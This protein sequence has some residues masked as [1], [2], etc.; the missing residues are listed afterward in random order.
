ME[1]PSSAKKPLRFQTH[2]ESPTK[3]DFYLKEG[4]LESLRHISGQLFLALHEERYVV[5]LFDSGV[6]LCNFVVLTSHMVP[7]SYAKKI[8][9]LSFH[10]SFFPTVPD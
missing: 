9:P 7:L 3:S 1:T 10:H 4:F 8:F 2:H 6:L 5:G